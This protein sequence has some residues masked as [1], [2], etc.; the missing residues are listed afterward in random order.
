MFGLG[1]FDGCN[2]VFADSKVRFIPRSELSRPAFR[3][4]ITR[5]GQ[6][7]AEDSEY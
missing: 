4:L 2:V 6:E 3:A 7:S 5:N 1:G